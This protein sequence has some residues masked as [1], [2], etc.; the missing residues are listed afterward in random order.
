MDTNE[1][2]L[3]KEIIE[4]LKK[5]NKDTKP[6]W[7]TMTPQHMIEHITGSWLISNG[8]FQ[9]KELSIP[10]EDLEKKRKFLFSD[11]PYK[12]N[13]TN[14]VQGEGLQP[15]RKPNLEESKSS[16]IQNINLFFN[17]HDTHQEAFF[18]H[19]VFG[20]LDRNGWVLFQTKH[21]K[22]HLEQFGLM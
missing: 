13:I 5:L 7:G 9:A 17:Y 11:V 22:H 15:L 18:L 19:P 21:I 14:P 4:I 10:E 3:K 6:L 20:D 8:R 16:L 2:F 1:S 12:K